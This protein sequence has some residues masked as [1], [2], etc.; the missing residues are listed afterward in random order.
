MDVTVEA[1]IDTTKT[2]KMKSAINST[3]HKYR[4]KKLNEL[5]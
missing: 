5:I 4:G 3:Q 2:D 1:L